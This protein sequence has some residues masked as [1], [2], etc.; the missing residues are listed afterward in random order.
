MRKATKIWLALVACL[1]LIGCILFGGVMAMLNW[2]FMKLSTGKSETNEYQITENYKSISILTDTADVVFVPSDNPFTSII[3]HED[4]NRKHTVTVE[5]GTLVIQLNDTRKWYEYIGFHFGTYKITISLP[6][7]QYGALSVKTDTGDVQITKDFTFQRIDIS[8]STGDVVDYA[9]A[10]ENIRIKMS[11][12]SIKME[13]VSAKG[14]SLSVSTGSI[15]VTNVTCEGDIKVNVSTGKTNLTNITGKNV[16]SEGSTGDIFLKN[17]IA[18]EKLSIERSTG[19]IHLDR[20]DAAEIS[21]ETD[22][23]DVVGSLLTAKVFIAET[24][25]GRVDVPKTTTG[26]KCEIE[27]DTGNIKITVL[28]LSH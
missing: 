12:G 18:T 11:T 23:G 22:T 10:L 9:S 6:R 19:D 27:T 21:I 25:T 2:D 14:I 16:I 5:D 1:I 13:N 28:N 26:G 3:C 24:D 4:I 20:C 8:G 15:A 17:V 7:G